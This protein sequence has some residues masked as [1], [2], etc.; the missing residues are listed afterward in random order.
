[1]NFVLVKTL[2]VEEHS[3]DTVNL[4]Y[5]MRDQLYFI[6][7]EAHLWK[8]YEDPENPQKLYCP[9]MAP[10]KPNK[11]TL[12]T[13]YSE[14]DISM[15]GSITAGIMLK[16]YGLLKDKENNM[17]KFCMISCCTLLPVYMYIR[18]LRWS[19]SHSE[20]SLIHDNMILSHCD[21]RTSH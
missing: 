7:S 11:H 17:M 13:Y 3:A 15:A 16:I 20:T 14:W 9:P 10:K 4:M 8:V 6:A 18:W 21:L 12:E 19:H 5:T 1:M 2:M